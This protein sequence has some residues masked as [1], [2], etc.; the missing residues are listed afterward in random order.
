MNRVRDWQRRL[1]ELDQQGELGLFSWSG[2]VST[3][4]VFI[5]FIGVAAGVFYAFERFTEGLLLVIVFLLAGILLVL[6]VKG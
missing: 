5:A 1:R 6:S 2:C 3:L 4:G